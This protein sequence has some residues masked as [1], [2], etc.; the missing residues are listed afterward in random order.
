MPQ[1][2]E[3]SINGEKKSLELPELTVKYLLANLGYAD[4]PV[5]IAV[6]NE[7]VPR[8]QFERYPVRDGQRIDILMPMQGG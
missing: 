5:A 4:V 8:T 2:L 6:N 7:F 3:L 1:T